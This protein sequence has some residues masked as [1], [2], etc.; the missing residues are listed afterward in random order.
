MTETLL[1]GIHISA[2]ALMTGIIWMV[3]LIQYPWINRCPTDHFTSY[4]TQY[5]TRIGFIVGP[6]M[7]IEG[8]T[9]V[10]LFT[11]YDGLAQS[12]VGQSLFVLLAIWISTAVLQVPCHQRLT[13][14]YD[15]SI[16]RKLVKTNWIRTVGWSLRLVLV[17]AASLVRTSEGFLIR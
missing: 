8:V 16:H 9:G 12:F 15:E 7:L 3:Q 17:I 10:W 13:K 6:A 4:H 5:M 14:G 1:M 11:L 2:T